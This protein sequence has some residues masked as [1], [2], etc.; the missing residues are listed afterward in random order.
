MLYVLG[1]APRTGKSTIA[2]RFVEEKQ[3][4]FF[5]IDQLIT[6]LQEIPALGIKHGDPFIQKADKLWPLTE[7]LLAGLVCDEPYYLIEGDGLLPENIAKLKLRFGN[8]IRS[9]FVGF[10]DIN[11]V[12][13]FN[14][15][16]KF[17]THQD[18]WTKKVT[19]DE[20][21]QNIRDMIEFSKYLK[22]ECE[23]FNIK[24]FDCSNNF[25][26]TRDDVFSYLLAPMK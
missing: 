13:K 26:Q 16:R 12:V 17:S 2:R 6:A 3:I 20:L 22:K 7:P 14:E 25:T 24:Y 19:D 21:L 15:I 9:C 18:D 23:V 4:P 1:G 8:L 10:A 5:C 11:P